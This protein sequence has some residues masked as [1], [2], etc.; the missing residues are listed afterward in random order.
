MPDLPVTLTAHPHEILLT[1]WS[2]NA[3]SH[4]RLEG[5]AAS[6][7]SM[8][9][10]SSFRSTV[11]CPA[12]EPTSLSGIEGFVFAGKSVAGGAPDR[13]L[14]YC[15]LNCSSSASGSCGSC[16][17]VTCGSTVWVDDGSG[18]GTDEKFASSRR[19]ESRTDQSGPGFA[20]SEPGP[21]CDVNLTRLKCSILNSAAAEQV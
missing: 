5:T 7:D 13:A 4:A 6:S 9:N 15:A 1:D 18:E 10:G 19:R 16:A 14:R 17:S 11:R 8:S 21:A 2:A 12:A 3:E 20:C